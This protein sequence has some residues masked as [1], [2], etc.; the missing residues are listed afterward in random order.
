MIIAFVRAQF[1]TGRM[2]TLSESIVSY[3]ALTFLYYGLAAPFVEYV[4]TFENP[5][6]GKIA[7]WLALII[8][9]PAMVGLTLG[10][11]AQNDVFRRLLQLLRIN[12]VHVTPTA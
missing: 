5:G 4:L 11:L 1:L 12:P 8:F 9:V 7:A 10:A 2:R 6:R 3:I